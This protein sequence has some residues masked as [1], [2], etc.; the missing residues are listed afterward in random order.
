[1]VHSVSPVPV[2]DLENPLETSYMVHS[3]SPV[4]V[5]DLE[6]PLETSYMV[7]SVSPVPSLWDLE[8]PSR[9][10]LYGPQR[11]PCTFIVGLGNTL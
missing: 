1:M 10:I 5:W 8:T 9:N 2:W 7:H 3:V 4:P 11:E 6:N